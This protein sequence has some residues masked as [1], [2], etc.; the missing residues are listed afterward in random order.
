MLVWARLDP[1]FAQSGALLPPLQRLVNGARGL[2]PLSDEELELLAWQ[3]HVDF[4]ETATTDAQLAAMILDSIPWHRIKGTPASIKQALGLFGYTA[5]IEEDG[6]GEYWATYQLGL[7]QIADVATVR[8][9]VAIASEMAPVRCRLWRLYSGFDRRPIV[10]AN[11]PVLGDG[12]L[13]YYSGVSVP[14]PDGTGG[15]DE[16]LVSFGIRNGYQ[17]EP[18]AAQAMTGSFGATTQYGFLAPY[19]DTFTVGRSRLTADAYPRNNPFMIGSLFS[20][21]WADRATTARRWRGEWDARRWLDFTGFD[22]KHP[23]WRMERRAVSKAQ[24]SLADQA[25]ADQGLSQINARLGVCFATVVNNPQRLGVSRLSNHD[26]GR[27]RVR[28]DEFFRATR[29]V[30][31]PAVHPS[32]P[33]TGHTAQLSVT[34]LLANL[35]RVRQAM[36]SEYSLRLTPK[37]WDKP[38]DATLLVRSITCP[39]LAPAVAQPTAITSYLA[40]LWRGAWNESGRTWTTSRQLSVQ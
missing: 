9:V 3:F 11:G 5:S 21:L 22:R 20:I 37:T 25:D 35:Q 8:R 6:V 31:T 15:E 7:P 17:A 2:K 27:E 12:W 40:L 34:S 4:R 32:A 10:L 13:S 28:I 19:L 23:L 36:H 33:Q 18:Y 39:A 16:V 26:S 38:Q 1:K 29:V 30:D 14:V 24:L